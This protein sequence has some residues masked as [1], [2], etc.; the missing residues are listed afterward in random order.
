[1]DD[2]C[3][4]MNQCHLGDNIVETANN[5]IN[6]LLPDCT[7]LD[8]DM[9]L[10]DLV[11]A[12]DELVS[13]FSNQL[14]DRDHLH[15]FLT[16]LTLLPRTLNYAE[17]QALI[18]GGVLMPIIKIFLSVTPTVSQHLYKYIVNEILEIVYQQIVLMGH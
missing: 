17:Q 1:M 18:N 16:D 5:L 8:R 2:L 12:L 10:S 4:S 11:L 7:Y 9:I 14:R 3:N 15:V 13:Q 6:L